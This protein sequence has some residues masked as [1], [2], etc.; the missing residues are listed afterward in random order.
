[1][2]ADIAASYKNVSHFTI[3]TSKYNTENAPLNV[4]AGAL[5]VY[6][7]SVQQIIVFSYTCQGR[8][9]MPRS[10]TTTNSA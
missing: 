8:N 4:A 7:R 6:H 9:H 3:K 5:S 1:M 2:F 10:T